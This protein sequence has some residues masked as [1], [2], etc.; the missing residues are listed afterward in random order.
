MSEKSGETWCQEQ[1]PGC[2]HYIYTEEAEREQEVGL[3][4]EASRPAHSDPL[5]PVRLHLL[6]VL[7]PSQSVPPAR[8]QVFKYMSIVGPFKLQLLFI[9]MKVQLSSN[10]ECEH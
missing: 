8:D 10:Q 2:S 7:Q 9:L 3:D 5:P 4:Y 1:E 6:K